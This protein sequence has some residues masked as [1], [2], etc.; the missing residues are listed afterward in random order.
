MRQAPQ[1][2]S[3]PAPAVVADLVHAQVRLVRALLDGV[4]ALEH[5]IAAAIAAHPWTELKTITSG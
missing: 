3:R 2:A 1:P 4:D 5:A